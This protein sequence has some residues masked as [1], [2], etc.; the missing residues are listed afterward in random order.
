MTAIDEIKGRIDIAALVGEQVQ[1]QRAGRNFRALCPFHSER[2]PSCPVSPERQTWHCFGA[3]GTGGDVISFV[4]RKEGVEFPEALRMLA[5]RAGVA[6]RERRESPEE[7]R[8]RGRLA[9]PARRGAP[10]PGTP[11]RQC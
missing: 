3:C 1:L 6:L 2:P 7:D 4:M 11:G 10:L 8:R 5:R 9:G